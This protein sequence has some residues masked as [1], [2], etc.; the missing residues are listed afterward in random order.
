[1]YET[2]KAQLRAVLGVA[3]KRDFVPKHRQ[4]HMSD[5]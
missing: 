2:F 4:K 1:M 3:E 5:S